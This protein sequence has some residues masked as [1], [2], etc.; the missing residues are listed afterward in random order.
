MKFKKFNFKN[1]N[2]TND[3]AI[4]L[5]KKTNNKFGIIVSD[6]QKNARG[7]FGRKWISYKGNLFVSLFFSLEKINLSLK[8]LTKIN[9]QLIKKLLSY[10]YKNKILIKPPNDLLVNKKKICGILQ[11]TITK[12]NINYFIVGVGINLIKSPTISNYPTTSILELTKV[13]VSKKK[14]ILELISLYEN[15]V[16]Q[17]SGSNLKSI[18]NL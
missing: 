14:I 7:R 9:C 4:R 10:Y 5:I 16:N 6:K 1:V 8:Q 2:S 11:E 12:A 15:F 13:N 17:F 3:I 18:K